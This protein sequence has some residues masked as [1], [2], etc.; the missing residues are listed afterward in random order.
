V[1]VLYNDQGRFLRFTSDPG[2]GN[3][4]VV[5][6]QAKIPI[7]AFVSDP[8]S[9]AIYGEQ[10]DAIVDSTILSIQEA[11]ER[12]QADIDMF[13]DPVFTVKFNTISA[14]ANLLFIGQQ[15]TLNSVKFGVA[16]KIVVIK[17]INCVARTPTQLEYQVQALGS[18]IVS[19]NDIM[20]TLLQQNLGQASTPAS[21]VLQVLIPLSETVPLTDA[22]T[23]VTTA[24]P[25]VWH[26]GSG[27]P[28]MNWGLSF[29]QA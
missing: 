10:Q 13:G 8:A 2:S 15:I 23:I 12:A 6:G 7:L 18:D 28:S 21:T 11:Q 26:P 20:L 19:F 5:Q 25:Y 9:I 14:L 3:S 4:I 16:D 24:G 29:W 22:V 27:Q 1:Q 17:Q